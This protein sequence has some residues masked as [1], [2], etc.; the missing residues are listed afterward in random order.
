MKMEFVY[1][2][3]FL[4]LLVFIVM[5]YWSGSSVLIISG[6]GGIIGAIIWM[7]FLLNTHRCEECHPYRG[8]E[9]LSAIAWFMFSV[10]TLLKAR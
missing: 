5:L 1:T 3:L 9:F 10:A 8:Y 7:T 4:I 2:I 6:V